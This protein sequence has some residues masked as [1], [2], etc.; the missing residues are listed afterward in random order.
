MVILSISLRLAGCADPLADLSYA[1][2]VFS[3]FGGLYNWG[4]NTSGEISGLSYLY[5]DG[6][7]T[8]LHVPGV[9]TPRR[10]GSMTLAKLSDSSSTH[11][12]DAA[13]IRGPRLCRVSPAKDG[14]N[15]AI[16]GGASAKRVLL[17]SIHSVV[18]PLSHRQAQQRTLANL[19]PLRD[20]GLRCAARK[21]L[22]WSLARVHT[23]P[24]LTTAQ[25]CCPLIRRFR[26]CR[27]PR[28]TLANKER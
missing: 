5:S 24:P 26:C 4:I 8:G 10:L 6:H 13:R 2:G 14:R 7:F 22:G 23:P 3:R 9:L 20:T 19:D 1:D 25:Q 27:V 28:N 17:P 16:I 21:G 11:R 12:D 15:V 18:M